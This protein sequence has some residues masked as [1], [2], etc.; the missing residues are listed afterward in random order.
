MDEQLLNIIRQVKDK[1]GAETVEAILAEIDKYPIKWRGTLRSSISYEQDPGL[2]GDVSVY[3]A[4]YGQFI[5]EGTGVFGPRGQRIPRQSIP[6]IA[7]HLK[8]WATSKNINPY[9]VATKIVER[10]GVKPRPFFTSVVEKRLN[11]L[12]LDIENAIVAYLEQSINNQQS[13]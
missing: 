10:G 3:M 12:G 9:A 5:D 7:Y 11:D 13:T 6:K 8:Q 2:D 4:D 1:W